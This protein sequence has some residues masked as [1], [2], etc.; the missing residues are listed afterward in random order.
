MRVFE[1]HK[2]AQLPLPFG[3]FRPA[4]ETDLHTLTH[5]AAAFFEE[6]GLRDPGD[7]AQEQISEG[8]LFAWEDEQPASMAAW[9]GRTGRAVRINFVFTPPDLRGRGYASACVASLTLRLLDEGLASCCLCSDLANP[10]SNR[11]YQAIG[12]RPVCDAGEYCLEAGQ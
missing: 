1:A 10:T 11:I 7:A 8:R 12:Y 9:V 6:A 2:A 5:W 4:A 3:R